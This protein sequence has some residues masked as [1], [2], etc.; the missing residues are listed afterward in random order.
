MWF[1]YTTIL[2]SYWRSV[3]HVIA[4]AKNREL[5]HVPAWSEFNRR[6]GTRGDVGI[7]HETYRVRPG[8]YESLYVNMP[9][10][11]LGKVGEL[12]EATGRREHAEDRFRV[13]GEDASA[14]E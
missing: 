11:G 1:G 6:V 14:S 5:A 8:D 4:Y 3:E 13:S 12:V 2:V 9:A 10:F 7:W